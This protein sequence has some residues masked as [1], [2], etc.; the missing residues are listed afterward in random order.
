MYKHLMRAQL[1]LLGFALL[2]TPAVLSESFWLRLACSG[3]LFACGMVAGYQLARHAQTVSR[4]MTG[5]T[6][7]AMIAAQGSPRPAINDKDYQ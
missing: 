2:L 4:K 1:A 7:C 3:A 5:G 6:P